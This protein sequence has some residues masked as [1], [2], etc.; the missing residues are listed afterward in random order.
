MIT[1]CTIIYIGCVVLAFKFIKIPVRPNTVATSVVVGVVILGGIL[2]GWKFAAPMT[3]QLTLKRNIVQVVPMAK[4]VIKRVHVVFDQPVKK[5]DLLLEMETAPFQASVD[6]LTAQLAEARQRVLGLDAAVE[7]ATAA[8]EKS[9]ADE[10]YSKAQLDAALKTQK[11]NPGAV[12]TLKVEVQRQNEL[13]AQ[14]GIV[15]A[16]AA[17]REAE[18]GLTSAKSGIAGIQAQL[19]TAK[20]NLER[21]FVRAPADGFVAN[22]Q[23]HEGTMGRTLAAS[24]VA[25][26]MDMSETVVIGVFPQNTLMYVE[27]GNVVEI[28]FKSRPGRIATGKV[29]AIVEYTGEG[30]LV[31]QSTLPIAADLGSKG[32]LVVRITLDDPKLAKELPLGAAGTLTIYTNVGSPFHIISKI[33]IRIKGWMNYLPM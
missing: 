2:I 3:G 9:K 17:L 1:V 31:A 15:Q 25:T 5:G 16:T 7:V 30:Q 4:E 28:A 20:L 21:C 18:F 33:T 10:A 12:A 29:D 23:A 32:F 11:L 19:N 13:A 26:F 27:P 24:A 14:A 6:Q 8:V 22:L